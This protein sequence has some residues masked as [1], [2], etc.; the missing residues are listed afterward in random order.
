MNA[1][2]TTRRIVAGAAAA[3]IATG[4]MAAPAQAATVGPR[5]NDGYCNITFSLEERAFQEKLA[6]D[7]RRIG[8]GAEDTITTIEQVFPKAK[9]IGERMLAGVDPLAPPTGPTAALTISDKD[10]AALKELGFTDDLIS[11]YMNAYFLRGSEAS[12]SKA[13]KPNWARTQGNYPHPAKEPYAYG[14]FGAELGSDLEAQL[15]RVWEN[16]PTGNYQKR[17][18]AL[19]NA[20]RES[21]IACGKGEQK[22]VEYPKADVAAGILGSV[23][24]DSDAGAIIGTIVGV[25]LAIAGIVTVLDQLGVKLP[26]QL[27]R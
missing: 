2:R 21:Q 5:G 25:L 3:A 4:A 10:R 14:F 16:T 12:R 24:P 22:A 9:P 15:T 8:N 17:M 13:P 11:K 20:D 19:V 1:Q 7:A 27:P 6:S 18:N 26:V 23:N